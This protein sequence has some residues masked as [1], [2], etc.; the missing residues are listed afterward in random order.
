MVRTCLDDG[1]LKFW[2]HGERPEDDDETIRKSAGKGWVVVTYEEDRR[3]LVPFGE[4]DA[5][6][7]VEQ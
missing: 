7:S 1:G 2:V 3:G 4:L 6:K 5:V